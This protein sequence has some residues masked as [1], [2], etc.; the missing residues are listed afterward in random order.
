MKK[1][2]SAKTA[3]TSRNKFSVINNPLPQKQPELPKFDSA[4]HLVKRMKPSMP[5][6]CMRTHVVETAAKWFVSAF[7]G[8]VMYAVKTNP[9]PLALKTVHEAGVRH[10]DVASLAEIELV[11]RECPGATMHYMHP[12]KSRDSI[13]FAY[14]KFSIRSFS[15]DSLAELAKIEAMTNNA[16]DLTLYVRLAVSN[17]HAALSLSGKFGCKGAE[18]VELLRAARGVAGKLGICFHVGSQCMD[19]E[20]YR[21][22]IAAARAVID[23]AGVKVDM[24]DVGGGFPS[25]YPDLAPV[26][27][28]SYMDVISASLNEYGFAEDYGVFCEPGRAIVAENGS[29][30]VKVEMRKGNM[31]Y[32]ND[33]VYGSLFDAGYPGFVYPARALRISSGFSG[34]MEA[35][36]FFGPTCDS[37]DMMKGP[38]MLPADICEG[39]WIEIGGLGAYSKTMQTNFNGFYSDKQ[40][41]LTDSPMLSMFGL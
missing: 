21:K 8:E 14:N 34:Q 17:E 18:A 9:D 36:G 4:H 1:T 11:A 30:V 24:I 31:L 22:A 39:D 2:T 29:V 33:G 16:R 5:V 25:I 32:I 26:S 40:A 37:L 15:L 28:Q 19:P 41:Q 23:E 10:F 6:H 35:F 38:F 27:L 13:M 7:P 20:D 3:R 12:V